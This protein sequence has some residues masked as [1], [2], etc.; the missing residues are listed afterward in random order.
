M[1][2]MKVLLLTTG[3][4]LSP[5]LLASTA[6]LTEWGTIASIAS[7]SCVN[8]SCTPDSVLATGI[9]VDPISNGYNQVSAATGPVTITQGTA[10]S[11][12]EIT[13]ALATP[14][15]KVKASSAS[16]SWIAAGAY[17]IQ[18]Y[19]YTGTGE[20]ISFDINFDGIL[21][22]PDSDTATGFAGGMYLFS[23]Q[24]MLAAQT[25]NSLVSEGPSFFSDP[26]VFSAVLALGTSSL[27]ANQMSEFEVHTGDAAGNVNESGQIDIDLIDGDQF[28]LVSAVL[29]SAGGTGA[30]ADAYSTFTAGVDPSFSG[31][32]DAVGMSAVPVPAA[33]WL[34]MTGLIGLVSAKRARTV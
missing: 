13:G 26:S 14:I 33:V 31:Q 2:N 30:I 7:G 25:L 19:E 24:Q 15:L 3:V 29:A 6:T 12:S 32:L 5:Q 21:T 1:K 23:A 18:G 10:Q 20:N 8:D 27:G 16:G 17:A 28:Y 11:S 9:T 22:N 4:F 34:F